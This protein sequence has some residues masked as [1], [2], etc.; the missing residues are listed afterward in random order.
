[1]TES[2]CSETAPFTP[3]L[4]YFVK[5]VSECWSIANVVIR[6]CPQYSIWWGI[7]GFAMEM[8]LFVARILRMHRATGGLTVWTLS[9][10]PR[11]SYVFNIGAHSIDMSYPHVG[12]ASI[13]LLA[14]ANWVWQVCDSVRECICTDGGSRSGH[15]VWPAEWEGMLWHMSK[16][17]TVNMQSIGHLALQPQGE[18]KRWHWTG[19]AIRYAPE[20]SPNKD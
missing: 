14:S 19:Q 1:M 20:H 17:P 9:R 4:V 16:N 13:W 3:T 11:F 6:I 8:L 15:T 18:R 2:D 5:Q 7:L 10:E 12:M